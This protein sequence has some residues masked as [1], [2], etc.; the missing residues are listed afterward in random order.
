MRAPP[1]ALAALLLTVPG[2]VRAP[3]GEGVDVFDA[4]VEHDEDLAFLFSWERVNR[5]DLTL[6]E[7][8]IRILQAE[9]PFTQPRNKV[10]ATVEIDGERV[11]DVGV[12]LRGGLGSFQRFDA[13]PKWEIDF[14]EFVGGQ[15]FHGLRSLSLNNFGPDGAYLRDAAGFSAFEAAGVPSSRTGLAQLFVNGE[16]YG[17]MSVVETQDARWLERVQG[18]DE[19]NLYDA[20]YAKIAMVVIFLDFGEGRD[21]LFDLD[22]GDPVGW[23]DVSAVSEALQASQDRGIVTET[24]QARVDMDSLHRVWAVEQ[25]LGDDDG[26]VSHRNNYRAWFPPEG[27]MVLSRWDMDGT[28]LLDV[29]DEVWSEPMGKLAELCLQDA[30][31]RSRHAEVVD[32][33]SSALDAASL[34]ERLEV[35]AARTEEGARHDPRGSCETGELDAERERLLDWIDGASEALRDQW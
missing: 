25:W 24:L 33:V 31:C 23:A 1:L 29:D 15:D 14:N 5:L 22:V 34:R 19:G 7:D 35:Y 8:A 10:R 18:T 21:D 2:C 26:Y 3:C 28:F 13:K 20:T 32:E 9:R 12:R 6:D 4:P 17:I 11:S 27:P 16:D 30:D